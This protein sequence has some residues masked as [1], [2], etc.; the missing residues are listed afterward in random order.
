[1]DLWKSAFV[2]HGHGRFSYGLENPNVAGFLLASIAITAAATLGTKESSVVC[3]NTKRLLPAIIELAAI[4]L[5]CLTYSRSA[6]LCLII[7]YLVVVVSA[8]MR[9]IA[10]CVALGWRAIA[11]LFLGYLTAFMDRVAEGL[12]VADQ[13]AQNRL[14]IWSSVWKMVK[15]A[16]VHGWGSGTSG[17]A[18]MNWFQNLGS[19]A[20]YR[21]L[22]SS[23]LTI[24]VEKGLPSAIAISTIPAIIIFSAL[25][26]NRSSNPFHRFCGKLVAAQAASWAVYNVFNYAAT[27]IITYAPVTIAICLSVVGV[28]LAPMEKIV[29]PSVRFLLFGTVAIVGLPVTCFLPLVFLEPARTDVSLA[30]GIVDVKS[31]RLQDS[32]RR[33]WVFP[34]EESLGSL[35]GKRLRLANVRGD[36]LLIAPQTN[37]MR[38][39]RCDLRDGDRVIIFGQRCREQI[40]FSGGEHAQFLFVNPTAFPF[41]SDYDHGNVHILLGGE[42]LQSR[43]IELLRAFENSGMQL[44]EVD[45][46]GTFVENATLR[47]ILLWD[48]HR[49]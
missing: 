33:I 1:M 17:W 26:L 10:C 32:G 48:L 49:G 20:G 23:P 16:P 31:N 44:T 7:G 38:Q 19:N 6:V 21:S 3:R 22:L 35:F 40:G 47:R 29:R 27:S 5:L 8:E 15:A 2:Y 45:W 28:A 24:A 41:G 12:A 30:E 9:A 14:I 43:N 18:Y 36:E 34:D 37:S 39:Y 11:T 46:E 25:R 13:S 4:W 42:S